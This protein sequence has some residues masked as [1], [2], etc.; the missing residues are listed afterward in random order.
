MEADDWEFL[1][2]P[3]RIEDVEHRHAGAPVYHLLDRLGCLRAVVGSLQAAQAVVK[4]VN[5]LGSVSQ[6]VR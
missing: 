6:S 3:W 5:G 4:A 1:K 2:I